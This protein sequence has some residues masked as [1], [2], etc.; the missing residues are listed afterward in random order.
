MEMAEGGEQG[1]VDHRRHAHRDDDLRRTS[2]EGLCGRLHPLCSKDHAPPSP[3]EDPG[4]LNC[5]NRGRGC[6]HGEKVAKFLRHGSACASHMGSE[7]LA[8]CGHRDEIAASTAG[9]ALAAMKSA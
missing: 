6:R 7:S 1:V 8:H 2:S 3:L 5:R 4:K 9:S